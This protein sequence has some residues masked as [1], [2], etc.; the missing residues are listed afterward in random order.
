[1][2]RSAAIGVRLWDAD[3]LQPPQLFALQHL[4]NLVSRYEV[5]IDDTRAWATIGSRKVGNLMSSEAE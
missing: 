5:S 3:H 4:T 1:L 2:S